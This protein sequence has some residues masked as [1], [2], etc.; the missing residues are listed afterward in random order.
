MTLGRTFSSI[1]GSIPTEEEEEKNEIGDKKIEE[2]TIPEGMVAIISSDGVKFTIPQTTASQCKLFK[3]ILDENNPFLES[4]EKT[5]HLE[6]NSKICGEIIRF[7]YFKENNGNKE[8]YSVPDELVLD[9]FAISDFL[10]I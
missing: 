4:N 3:N 10:G 1:I 6:Y 8:N 2:E 7:L 5:I 9:L